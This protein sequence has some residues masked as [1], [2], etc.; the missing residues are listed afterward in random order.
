MAI[1]AAT[2]LPI[3]LSALFHAPTLRQ[4]AARLDRAG[5]ATPDQLRLLDRQRAFLQTWTGDQLQP[6]ALLF[7][8]N[9][10][11]LHHPLFWCLQGYEEFHA[12]SRHLGPNRPVV[13]MRSGHL[14]MDY[15][16]PNVALLADVYVAEILELQPEGPLML[17]GNCQAATLTIAMAKALRAKG[18]DIALV[19]LMEEPAFPPLNGKVALL[20]GQDSHL[21]PF[22]QTDPSARIAAAYP[23][24]ASVDFVPG[25]HGQLFTANLGRILRARLAEVDP[26]VPARLSV[27]GKV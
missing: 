13:G 22:A 5:T 3:D 15:S 10:G 7:A 19:F 6:S 1:E 4:F 23:D 9:A 18:R 12:L 17:G 11:G 21:N 14:I 26:A 24:G 27:A 2:G 8:K 20:F 16:E 25:G